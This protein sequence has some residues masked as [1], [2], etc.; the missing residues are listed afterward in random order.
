MR[1]HHCRDKLIMIFYTFIYMQ[2]LEIMTAADSVACDSRCLVGY[3]ENILQHYVNFGN[4][5]LNEDNYDRRSSNSNIYYNYHCIYIATIKTG[6]KTSSPSLFSRIVK[7]AKYV[8]ARESLTPVGRG[9]TK[10]KE[11]NFPLLVPLLSNGN[12]VLAHTLACS[13]IPIQNEG[14]LIVYYYNQRQQRLTNTT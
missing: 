11:R 12:F 6:Y 14:L 2:L 3:N 13:S 1:T 5:N 7:Q 10:K 9:E 8:S 4:T